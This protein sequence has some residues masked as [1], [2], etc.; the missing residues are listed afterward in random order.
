MIENLDSILENT[1]TVIDSY[2]KLTGGNY[3]ATIPWVRSM[4]GAPVIRNLSLEG[5]TD[6]GEALREVLTHKTVDDKV[7]DAFNKGEFKFNLAHGFHGNGFESLDQ[8]TKVFLKR[9]EAEYLPTYK[10]YREHLDQHDE[11]KN[12]RHVMLG[13]LRGVTAGAFVGAGVDGLSCLL[14]SHGIYWEIGARALPALLEAE[15]IARPFARRGLDWTKYKTGKSVQKPKPFTPTEIWSLTQLAGP[16]IGFGMLIAGEQTGLNENPAYKATAVVTVNT[17][18]NVI[19]S[20]SSYVHFYRDARKT[21]L[22]GDDF[23][24][25]SYK[26]QAT[27]LRDRVDN[28]IYALAQKHNLVKKIINNLGDVYLSLCNFWTDS[29]QSSNVVVASSWL[30]TEMVLRYF[31]IAAE[32]VQFAGCF[33]GKTLAAIESGLLSC[34]TAAAAKTAIERE[35]LK[36]HSEVRKL[37]DRNYLARLYVA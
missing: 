19:G 10:Q 29:F 14:D 24:Y 23:F 37:V 32:N 9:W 26:P 16:L 28:R 31:G 36:L 35:K 13:A 33:G 11:I 22:D 1:T 17:G 12:Y 4:R 20:G 3:L 5:K 6:H 30:G 18:N 27:K 2:D 21:R 25:L 8:R 7:R 15:E 34:D